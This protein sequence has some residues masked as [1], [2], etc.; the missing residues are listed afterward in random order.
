MYRTKSGASKSALCKHILQALKLHVACSFV[1][2][3]PD[4]SWDLVVKRDIFSKI[5]G[6]VRDYKQLMIAGVYYKILIAAVAAQAE[7]N[8]EMNL[9]R[10]SACF[11]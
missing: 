1:D 11:L 10:V 6:A 8:F 5:Q 2:D 3:A 7:Q 4:G 9:L